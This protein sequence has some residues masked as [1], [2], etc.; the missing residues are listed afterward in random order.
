MEEQMRLFSVPKS[1]LTKSRMPLY[2]TEIIEGSE[3]YVYWKK[4]WSEAQAKK[5]SAKEHNSARGFIESAYVKFGKV[6][7]MEGGKRK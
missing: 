1:I 4:A 5:L 7:K 3:V 6:K 2:C